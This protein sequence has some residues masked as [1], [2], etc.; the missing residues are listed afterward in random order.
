VLPS[1]S[2]AYTRPVEEKLAAWRALR[3][4]LEER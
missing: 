4:F 2:P 3:E 1:T